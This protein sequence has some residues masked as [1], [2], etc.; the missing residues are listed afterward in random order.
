MDKNQKKSL[1]QAWRDEEREK[2]RRAFPLPVDELI[3]L[4]DMLDRELPHNPCNHTRRLTQAWLESRGHNV[5][6]MFAWLDEHNGFC[7]CQILGNVEQH[8]IDNAS[9]T[10]G[11]E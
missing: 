3:Q 1:K 6:R 4:F 5:E 11:R 9:R 7:D 2:S 8:V 10:R